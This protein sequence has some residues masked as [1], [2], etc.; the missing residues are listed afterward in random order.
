MEYIARFLAA[1]GRPT[2][3]FLVHLNRLAKLGVDTLNWTLIKPF[4][5]RKLRIRS[6]IEQSVRIGW[7]SVPIVSIIAFFVGL[8]LAMQAAYQ[9]KPFGATI[10]VANLVAVAQTR[11]LGP[12]ITAIVIAG[13]SGS[14][15]AAEIGTMKVAEE[16]DALQTMGLN[17]IGFL[18]V[19][20]FL[21]MCLMLPALVLIADIVGILGAYVFSI[22]A[23][24][25]TSARFINQTATALVMKDVITGLVKTVFFGI[26]IAGVGCYQGFIVDG[27]AE[28]VGR[29]TTNSV[30]VSIFLIIFA[31]VLFTAMFLFFF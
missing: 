30:V 7:N 27:G 21:A 26:I 28:G 6:A 19:P 14:S 10:Y 2:L 18:V 17:P 20:R 9:L 15:I 22:S 13:R 11:S 29:S 4:K 5:G 25:I 3:G 12:I 31:D 23:L 16:L 8:I 24:D 1:L